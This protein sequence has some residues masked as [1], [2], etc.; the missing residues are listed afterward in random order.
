M[1]ENDPFILHIRYHDST[2]ASDATKWAT[3]TMLS[4]QYPTIIQ[5]SVSKGFTATP[6]IIFANDISCSY[7]HGCV[8]LLFHEDVIE[9]KHFPRYWPFVR[10]IHLSPVNSPPKGQCSGALVF[11]L[12]CSWINGWVNNGEAGDLRRHRAHYDVAVMRFSYITSSRFKEGVFTHIPQ[13]CS[14]DT[15]IYRLP[16]CK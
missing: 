4:T 9:W 1:K 16:H 2:W 8:V 7:A 6:T 11:S 13:G 3:A 5:A 12:I 15:A 14:I 10:G